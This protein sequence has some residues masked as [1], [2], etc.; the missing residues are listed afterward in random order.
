MAQWLVTQK[1]SQFGVASLN[2]LKELAQGGRLVAGD[3]IQPPGSNGWLYATEIPE[4][5]DLVPDEPFA[6]GGGMGRY[7]VVG[8]ASAAMLLLSLAFTVMAALS[9]MTSMTTQTIIGEGGLKTSEMLVTAEGSGLRADPDVAAAVT[10][11]VSKDGV[12]ELL[13]KRGNFYRARTA[14]GQ[15]GWIPTD[16]VLPMYQLGGK[17]A[18]EEYD[19]LYNP[20]RYV[21]VG[22]AAWML[23]ENSDQR[24]V[25]RFELMNRSRYEMTGLRLIATVKDG[26]GSEIEKVEFS[27]E[28]VIP[29]AEQGGAGSTTV[30]TLSQSKSEPGKLYTE[31][32]F[33]KMAKEAPDLQSHWLDGVEVSMKTKDFAVATVNLVEV[34]AVP[35]AVE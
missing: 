18:K 35:T 3:M 6:G 12:V 21:E 30:G 26:Q 20:D 16:H 22:S 29:P 24:T 15:E 17:E 9:F 1:D 10:I 4:L 32:T 14:D 5:K 19:P 34:S 23:A 28:G 7:L 33:Q 8:L 11:P 31:Y 27:V 25:F 13:A 2:E